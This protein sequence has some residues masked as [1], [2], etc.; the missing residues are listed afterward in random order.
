MG[1]IGSSTVFLGR[2]VSPFILL[3]TQERAQPSQRI[4]RNYQSRS[5][6]SL[7]ASNIAITTAFLVLHRIGVQDII[8]AITSQAEWEV[9]VVQHSTLD[10]LGIFL[11]NGK[12]VVHSGKSI[13]AEGVG[14]GNV[15]SDVAVRALGIW[16]EGSNK[17]FV[18]SIGEVK[19]FLAVWVRF[20]GRDGVGD[21]GVGGEML[22]KTKD[23]QE[24]VKLGC[25]VLL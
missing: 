24:S 2:V 22:K 21:D 12:G 20:E 1:V 18:A 13:G 9:C 8:L 23:Q 14:F 10:F 4:A 6:Y 7:G 5:D 3:L 11:H 16:D 17:L 15:W 19:R 25:V